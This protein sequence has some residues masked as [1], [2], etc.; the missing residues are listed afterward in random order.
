MTDRPNSVAPQSGTGVIQ[1]TDDALAYYRLPPRLAVLNPFFNGSRFFDPAI[2]RNYRLRDRPLV[3]TA[4]DL[5]INQADEAVNDD[6]DL[7]SLTDIRLFVYYTDFTAD[8]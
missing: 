7:Q 5:V 2:Y 1:G 3:N 4:W 6:L 8:L